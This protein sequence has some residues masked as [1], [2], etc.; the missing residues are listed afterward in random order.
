MGIKNLSGLAER[1]RAHLKANGP[2]RF[3][4]LCT[5]MGVSQS[6]GLIDGLTRI[7][8]DLYLEDDNRLNVISR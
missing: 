8:P 6:R 2:T 5:A 7:M 1:V 4:H 3:T